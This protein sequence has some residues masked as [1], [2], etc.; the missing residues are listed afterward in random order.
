MDKNITSAYARSILSLVDSNYYYHEPIFLPDPENPLKMSKPFKQLK[1]EDNQLKVFPNPAKEF[2]IIDYQIND[3]L[4]NTRLELI[5]AT[6]RKVQ[7]IE[8]KTAKGQTMIKTGNLAKGLYH[9]Y[10]QNN[11]TTVSQTKITIE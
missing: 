1:K 8:L 9:C 10:L 2:F 11:D 7:T 4:M 3:I 5:D 6:G